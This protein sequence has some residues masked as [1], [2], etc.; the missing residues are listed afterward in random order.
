MNMKSKAFQG[1]FGKT[2][3]IVL[4]V[5]M[6]LTGSVGVPKV[7]AED[8]TPP[9]AEESDSILSDLPEMAPVPVPAEVVVAVIDTGVDYNHKDLADKMKL[10]EGGVKGYNAITKQQLGFMDDS[11]DSHGT[12][13]AGIIAA[14][15]SEDCNI[16]IMPVKALD[17][18]GNAEIGNVADAIRWA[19]ENGAD[20]IN[21]SVGEWLTRDNYPYELSVAVSSA[22]EKGI[23]IVAAAGNTGENIRQEDKSYYPAC[24][25]GVLSV[26]STGPDLQPSAF[27]NIGAEVYEIGEDVYSTQ[28]GGAYGYADGTSLA[29]AHVSGREAVKLYTARAASMNSVPFPDHKN[30]SAVDQTD[31]DFTHEVVPADAVPTWPV[32]PDG[33]TVSTT[34]RSSTSISLSWTPA[35]DDVGVT[36][37]KIQMQTGYTLIGTVECTGTTY[38]FTGLSPKTEYTFWIQAF[39]GDGEFSSILMLIVSTHPEAMPGI[40]RLWINAPRTGLGGS[41]YMGDIVKIDLVS[42]ETGLRPEVTVFYR[43]WNSG[44]TAVE[45]KT[46]RLTL[47]E[48][49]SGSRRY[50]A[51]FPLTEGICEITAL[52]GELPQGV[53]ERFD[54]NQKVAGR[55]K[56]TVHAPGGLDAEQ[57]LIF[58]NI[59]AGS[60]A[61]VKSASA[62][63][64]FTTVITAPGQFMVEGLLQGEDYTLTHY[65]S[66]TM[67][68][69]RQDI[70]AVKDG[71]ETEFEYTLNSPSNIKIR[72]VDD[73]T[74]EPIE[75]I[76]V[77]SKP[78]T[79]LYGS[80]H[81]IFAITGRDGYAIAAGS[82]FVKNIL[83]GCRLELMAANNDMSAGITG[84]YENKPIIVESLKLGENTVEIRMAKARTTTLRGTVT[85]HLGRPIKK[86]YI[87]MLQKTGSG[88]N[89]NSYAETDE[90]GRYTMPVARIPGEVSFS[91]NTNTIKKQAEL[92]EN[93]ESFV[94]NAAI[95]LPP[96]PATVRVI[97]ETMNVAGIT[98]KMDVNWSVA[99]HMGVTVYNKN[100][101][102]HGGLRNLED[103]IYYVP[104]SPG[105]EI[106]V[107]ADGFQGGFGTGT[108]TAILDANNHAEV[109][110]VLKPNTKAYTYV[111]DSTGEGR[112]GESRYMSVYNAD[113]GRFMYSSSSQA[114]LIY[115]T[116]P[117]GSYKA[118]FSWRAKWWPTLSGWE[119]DPNCIITESFRVEG[120][121]VT[122]LG[123]K[124]VP[125]EG[126]GYFNCSTRNNLTSSHGEA[127]PG[128]V[129]TLSA[130]YD[131]SGNPGPIDPGRLE[132]I[133]L[134]PAGTTYVA[135][136]A[137]SR[138]AS[139]TI[140]A[141]QPVVGR[142]SI[143]LDLKDGIGG[144][145][146][147]SL[148]YQVKVN[149]PVVYENIM[150]NA[151]IKF[152]AGGIL[153]SEI[154]GAVIIPARRITINAP[155]EIAKSNAARPVKFGGFAP[156]NEMVDLYDGSLKIGEAKAS[157]I[158]VWAAEVLLPDRGTPIYHFITVKA[159][160]D[161]REV[162]DTAQV[163][164]GL[165]KAVMTEFTMTQGTRT[166]KIDP[167]DGVAS[168]PFVI[169]PSEGNM[170]VTVRFDNG[171]RVENVK[172]SGYEAVRQGDTFHTRIPYNIKE[173]TVQYDEDKIQN[174]KI[175]RFDHGEVPACIKEAGAEFVNGTAADIRLEYGADGYIRA[176]HMPEIKLTVQEEAFTTSMRV[177]TVSFDP[178]TAANRTDLGDGL[179][180]Y[181]FSY[182]ETGGGKYVITA[183]L[184]RRLLKRP[185]AYHANRQT[186]LRAAN[187]KLEVAKVVIEIVGDVDKVKGAFGDVSAIAKTA[188]LS[189]MLETVRPNLQPHM[190][191]YYENQ[192]RAIGKDFA[193]GK[194]LGLIG[195][196]AGEAGN[197]VPLLGQ[198]VAGVAGL[199]SGKLLGDM[200]DN[201]FEADYNRL[202]SM[203]RNELGGNTRDYGRRGIEDYGDYWRIYSSVAKPHWIMDPSGFVYEAVD[204]NRLQGVTATA[205]Y[206][207]KEEARDADE[208][209]A[210][211]N[212]Q[213][214]DAGWYLQENPQVTGPDG[215]YAWDV[216]EGWWMVQFVKDGYQTA[217]SDPLPVP[218]PQVDINI[219]MVKLSRPVV[220]RTVWGGGGRYVDIY[221][222]KYMDISILGASNAVRL[223][224]SNGTSVSGSV[225]CAV[226]DKAGVNG[227][228][229]TKIA[230]YQPKEALT[231]GQYTLT[232]NRAVADYAG[233]SMTADYTETGSISE[234]APILS[235]SG[236]NITVAPVMDITKA[237][238]EAITFTAVDPTLWGS[239]DR[240]LI[241]SSANANVIKISE[242]GTI[243]SLGKGKAEITA[244]AMDDST[245]T[246]HFT[247]TVAYPPSPVSITNMAIRDTKGSILVSLSLQ[248]GETYILSP[249]ITPEHA[250]NKKVTYTSDHSSVATVSPSGSITAVS[251]GI[252]TI[253]AKTEDQNIRQKIIIK[254]LP[255]QQTG[256][257]GTSS[258]KDSGAALTPTIPNTV[259]NKKPN[260]PTMASTTLT[261]ATDKKGIVTVTVTE[262]QTRV[263]INAAKKNAGST[264]KAADGIGVVFHIQFSTGGKRVRESSA[265]QTNINLTNGNMTPDNLVEFKVSLEEKV[266]TLLQKEGVK[267]F[268]VNTPLV[269]FSFDKIAILEMKSLTSGTVT[270][271]VKPIRKLPK[272]AKALISKRPV[273][274]LS[275]SCKKNGKTIYISNFKK[276]TVMLGIPYR[277]ESGE[278]TGNLYGVYVNEKGQAQLL[279]NSS[280][281]NGKVIFRRNSLSAYGIGYKAPAPAFTDTTKHWAKDN[282]DFVASRDLIKGIST[283]TFSPDTAITRA[284]FLMALG[285]LSG[286]DVSIYKTSGFTDVKNSDPAMP[287][288]EWA[289]K[290]KILQGK[291]INASDR[292]ILGIDP[293]G[294]GKFG[295]DQ[296]ITREQ[297]AEI[298]VSY[299]KA[300]GYKLPVSREAVA[301]S[302][303]AKINSIAK[304]AVTTIQ[305]TGIIVGRNNNAV[306]SCEYDPQG[307][308]T[309][310]E[311]STFLRRFIEL[312]I[313]EDTA[314]GWSR[315]DSG[316]QQYINTD[317]KAAIGWLVMEKTK[318]YFTADGI[319]VSG[320]WM[321]IDGK[322][323]YFYADGSL[324]R[325]TK[326]DG[327]EV[328]ENGVRKTN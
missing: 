191:E 167:R 117:D 194:T 125:Y 297:M 190:E 98:T 246:A 285:K 99:I 302:D 10:S 212:W 310:A 136:S 92:K 245:K 328:D 2:L 170:L 64:V 91:A 65:S 162:S 294:N 123:T 6:L 7:Y 72:V 62:S 209:K 299:A 53:S 54:I 256:D 131:Y 61:S 183:Y 179:Y 77:V 111:M 110:L 75:N 32:W 305:Q 52:E 233:F 214:W 173:I 142:D 153:H 47:A 286:A 109:R 23:L 161:G 181:D 207:S 51:D 15:I 224:D 90:N 235:L 150:A 20:I 244:T 180:G 276:G 76:R 11:I 171:E 88:L 93:M 143:S 193:M 259:I 278:K 184:D 226:P 186:T 39:D 185:E 319:M 266:I 314:R 236:A 269:N 89:L 304:D 311:A 287:Y 200:F 242:D 119:G 208:A 154:I 210:S 28:I 100:T 46:R 182:E 30:L 270:I 265:D 219:P 296:Q 275:I 189:E 158:G 165:N 70:P 264:G 132:L 229:L 247:V 230:R 163:L 60:L 146:S 80:D 283:K 121:S 5:A 272:S 288:I 116:L 252:A 309:R 45:D 218:P 293:S 268:D 67:I 228:S 73:E 22:L 187:T 254:V 248:K 217:Y 94:L 120:G 160:A 133:A 95:P 1:A 172:I 4:A 313:C 223:A 148:S 36:G 176:F 159:M 56:A 281:D 262:A 284:V 312:V 263:L 174:E 141:A 144:G 202:M 307:S 322:Q 168:F 3:A 196:V 291:G 195:D 267:R 127:I 85:D 289:I 71:L 271:A 316:Q 9:V 66:D 145:V 282:I 12:M 306:H 34:D 59:L 157:A 118:V 57:T 40:A 198:V 87:S 135:G 96:S 14:G 323:Y 58:N 68:F 81:S 199:I 115:F 140:G 292:N 69:F 215:K 126:E 43:E 318:Y 106:Q 134:I 315:N 37:Y 250:A 211:S 258:G 55:L 274:D 255:K 240:R 107:A 321:Q 203:L 238:N 27:S 50:T 48:T 221:F 237:V 139:G 147:G 38:E 303:D 169:I 152:L 103:S 301:F 44:H 222:S 8:T 257:Q 227:L 320:K 206:L 124:E 79:F 308:V 97:L 164:V 26:G 260:Q 175:L 213:F 102:M 113:N 63:G 216:P 295:P 273:Y 82:H 178:T 21:L 188:Q 29:A 192:L 25:P 241:F 19:V 138:V 197:L 177:E 280:Y 325:S 234:A 17:A 243:S 112:F 277:P 108:A 41:L 201:E 232:I 31:G 114:P 300:T 16:K 42:G 324:A 225:I 327:Y 130:S 149:D 155:A 35:R 279:A 13:A 24:L 166:T 261:A 122:G 78:L 151:E 249:D 104:G 105:N 156:A 86:A 239:L 33:S 137:V 128:T 326:V 251:E 18:N 129:I 298:M 220:E 49:S 317:G 204:D 84:L 83:S 205:L 253:T 290:N 74:G 231:P 101:F